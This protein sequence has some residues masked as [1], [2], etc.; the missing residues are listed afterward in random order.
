MSIVW[1]G[2]DITAGAFIEVIHGLTTYQTRYD[3]AWRVKEHALVILWGDWRE[4][5][6]KVPKL[7][8][9]IAHFNPGTRCI[10][11]TCGHWLPN[12]IGQYYPVLKRV[13][14]CF[15][16]C[17]AG[18]AHCRPIISVDDTFLTGKYK[19]TSMIAVGMTTENYTIFI[20]VKYY[21]SH[22]C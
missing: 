3:K 22:F 20:Q 11:N 17:V 21:Y 18:F 2:S 16:R 14:W 19:G 1:A 8:H 4:A 12:E 5:Y 15:S 13:F 10:I 7:L 6:A 9:A